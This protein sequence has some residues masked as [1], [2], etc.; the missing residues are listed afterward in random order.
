MTA[1]QYPRLADVF[2]GLTAEIIA[3][4]REQNENDSLVDVVEDLPFYGVCTCSFTCTNL[5]T[6]PLGSSGTWIVRL[7]RD[8]EDV[9][10]LS[11][12]PTGTTITAI[13]VL[14]GRDLGPASR[15]RSVPSVMISQAIAHE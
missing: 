8:G 1:G 6:A 12:A 14:D 10:W 13:E 5:L 9:I 7:E 11:L 4:L 15:R 3:L 2:S